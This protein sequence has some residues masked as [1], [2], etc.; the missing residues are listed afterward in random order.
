MTQHSMA[1]HVMASRQP[2]STGLFE[3]RTMKVKDGII[4]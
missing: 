2:E 1:W 4:E 3:Q